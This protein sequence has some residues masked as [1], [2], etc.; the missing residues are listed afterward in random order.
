MRISDWSSDVCSSDLL[1][2]YRRDR[3]AWRGDASWAL[4]SGEQ[5]TNLVMTMSNSQVFGSPMILTGHKP[6]SP[7]GAASMIHTG[8]PAAAETGRRLKEVVRGLL[9]PRGRDPR[10]RNPVEGLSEL[11]DR[12]LR[13][14]GPHRT[15]IL[16]SPP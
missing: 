2:R 15:H 13:D 5:P 3:S 1:Y 16:R 6:V 14:I 4:R 8:E 9:V 12:M 11:G 10:I 7:L